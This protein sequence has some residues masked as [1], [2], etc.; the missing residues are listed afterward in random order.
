M[1]KLFIAVA[2]AATVTALAVSG[3][4]DFQNRQRKRAESVFETTPAPTPQTVRWIKRDA[5]W[6]D[7]FHDDIHHVMCYVWRGGISCIPDTL[8]DQSG[9]KVE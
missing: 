2:I 8:I 1:I 9:G 6:P 4:R 5:Q 7:I 3:Y